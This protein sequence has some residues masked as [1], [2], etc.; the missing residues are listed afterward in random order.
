MAG[1]ALPLEMDNCPS[2]ANKL[3]IETRGRAST[4]CK[5][6]WSPKRP[7]LHKMH[8]LCKKY[9]RVGFKQIYNS[10]QLY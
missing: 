9:Y 2:K 8:T 5:K 6:N 1:G 4:R 3:D 7:S 10:M